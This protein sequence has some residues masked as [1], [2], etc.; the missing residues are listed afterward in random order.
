MGGA[1]APTLLCRTNMQAPAICAESIGAEAP[2]TARVGLASL[3][4]PPRTEPSQAKPN[5]T[6]SN[7]A[8][9]DPSPTRAEA[10]A[11]EGQANPRAKKRR[12]PEGA[13][14]RCH[15]ASISTSFRY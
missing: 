5:Q 14:R 2:P 6:K 15:R 12:A 4:S 9:R 3:A 11:R 13:R 1:S 8:V 7:Q 10:A